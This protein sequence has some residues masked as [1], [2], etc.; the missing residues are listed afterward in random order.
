MYLL[1]KTELDTKKEYLPSWYNWCVITFKQR[2]WS[3]WLQ[4]SS[5]CSTVRVYILAEAL[6]HSNEMFWRS[7]FLIWSDALIECMCVHFNIQ[8]Y[9][10]KSLTT[11]LAVQE[12]YVPFWGESRTPDQNSASQVFWTLQSFCGRKMASTTRGNEF[13][14]HQ[15]LPS[16]PMTFL[17]FPTSFCQ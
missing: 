17:Q 4:C 15:I 6:L 16:N 11:Q 8:N 14:I 9:K 1:A 5:S 10:Y 12:L 2:K 3:V 7:K 13:I